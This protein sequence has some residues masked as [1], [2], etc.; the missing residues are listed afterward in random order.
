MFCR[1]LMGDRSL[2]DD[3]YQDALVIAFTKVEDLRDPAAFRPWLYRIIVSTFHSTIRRPWWKRRAPLTAEAEL[4]LT[5]RDPLSVHAA[6]RWLNRAYLA[7]SAEDQALVTLHELEGWAVSD[8]ADLMGKS[9][10][11]IKAR[12]FRARRKMK[13]SLLKYTRQAGQKGTARS[14]SSRSEKCAAAKPGIE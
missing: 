14:I 12:L 11:S 5:S 10:G 4:R 7:I 1:K 9:E 13:D 8:L 6:R 3:L 2:G